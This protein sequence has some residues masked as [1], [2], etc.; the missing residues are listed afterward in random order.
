[1]KNLDASSSLL[2]RDAL[3]IFGA[4]LKAADAGEAVRRSLHIRSGEIRAGNARLRAVD[5]D[6]VFLLAVGKA[7]VPMALAVEAKLGTRLSGG[8]I[9]TK[10]GHQTRQLPGLRVH[11]AGHPVPDEAGIRASRAAMELLRKLNARDLLLLAISGGASA[12][13]TAP[14]EP[15]TLRDKQSTTQLLLRAGADIAQL[16]CVRKHLSALKGG[17][18]AQLAHPATVV[19]LILSDVIGDP[20]DV[21]GSGP[22]APDP[23]TFADALAVLDQFDLAGRVPKVVREH[24]K[25]GSAGERPD[26]PKA[27]NR[28][29]KAVHNVVIG[30]NR[31]ALKAA[32]QE[33]RRRGYRTIV[34][35]STMAGETREVAAVHAHIL[36]EIRESGNPLPA[37][38]CV[39][40][41][42][43]TT[44]T[45]TGSGKGGRNQEFA[46]AGA[47]GI[48]GVRDVLILSGGTDGTDGPTDAAGAIATADTVNRAKK[49]GL[50]AADYLKRNDAYPFFE[51]LGDLVKTGPTGT[52]VMDIHILLAR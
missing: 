51:A 9:I 31:L 6:R 11:E 43:E 20:P 52:N 49:K 14:E 10:H 22:T 41:G 50:Q 39:L 23:S 7:S 1:M 18:L 3:A 48:Q 5:F 12:L 24:L 34:L 15:V 47:M 36:R 46:L 42:G 27:D 21:I 38:A 17:R 37:P 25:Q 29:F 16:N 8:L 45:V 13:L 32:K 30:S 33:A 26:T 28:I 35:S 2:R 4:A 19:S 40:S 44:V